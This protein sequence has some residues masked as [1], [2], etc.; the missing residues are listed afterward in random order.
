MSFISTAVHFESSSEILYLFDCSIRGENM[1][2]TSVMH[3]SNIQ[4]N[5]TQSV[6]L[7]VLKL[8]LHKEQGSIKPNPGVFALSVNTIYSNK[9]QK[10]WNTF[11]VP[12]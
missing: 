7:F 12:S 3:Q 10:L 4:L 2:F 5:N 8:Y 1:S 11:T 6:R 9:C